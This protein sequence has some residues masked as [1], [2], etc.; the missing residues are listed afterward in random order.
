MHVHLFKELSSLVLGTEIESSTGVPL[1]NLRSD[2]QG[3]SFGPYGS[4]KTIILS[5][6]IPGLPF[7]PGVYQCYPWFAQRRGK[8]VDHLH[9]GIEIII[10]SGGYYKSEKMFQQGKGIVVMDCEWFEETNP[11]QNVSLDYSC[12]I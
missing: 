3:V 6:K 9:E 1:L 12:G 10:E 5:F 2:S 8:R 11:A 7:Y 4:D